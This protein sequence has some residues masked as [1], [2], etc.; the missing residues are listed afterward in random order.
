MNWVRASIRN[1]T[2]KV[3]HSSV[4][5]AKIIN[6]ITARQKWRAPCR[7][8]QKYLLV[9]RNLSLLKPSN[10]S[11]IGGREPRIFITIITS[12]RLQI[13]LQSPTS[14]LRQILF[15]RWIVFDCSLVFSSSFSCRWFCH[16]LIFLFIFHFLSFFI[17]IYYILLL[18][19]AS[20]PILKSCFTGRL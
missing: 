14:V 15:F 19:L 13:F 20:F 17:P 11:R 16:W 4:Y 3:T 10:L 6:S 2:W 12:R 1:S 7:M 9:I 8:S 5:T 18:E